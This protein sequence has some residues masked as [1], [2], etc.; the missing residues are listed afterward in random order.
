MDIKANTLV[1]IGS[2]EGAS[3]SSEIHPCI[4]AS[5]GSFEEDQ[6]RREVKIYEILSTHPPCPTI[7]QC[8]FCADNG[9]FLEY[10][11]GEI[12]CDS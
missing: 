11:R 9:I 3:L 12:P 7:V 4:V 2:G 1:C 10:M 6:F 5:P 8:F